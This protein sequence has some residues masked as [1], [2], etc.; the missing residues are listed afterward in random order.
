MKLFP[1]F[2]IATALLLLPAGT[3]AAER[4]S[5]DMPALDAATVN[6]YCTYKSG[7]KNY[8]TTGTGIM[9]G[10]RGVILTNAHVVLPLLIENPKNKS[11][12]AVRAGSPAREVYTASLLYLAPSWLEETLPALRKR[13][14]RGSGD[15][16]FALLYVASSTSSTSFPGLALPLIPSA[17][18]EGE[19][20]ILAGY[21][22]EG[23]GYKK[24]A[25]KLMYETDATEVASVHSF[26]R[27]F[28]DVLSL[29][30]SSLARSG[31]S[32]GPVARSSGE[33]VGLMTAVEQSEKKSERKLR[34]ITLSYI[35]RAITLQTGLPLSLLIS[36]NLDARAALTEAGLPDELVKDVASAQLRRR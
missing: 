13:V 20:V 4:D 3:F 26:I 21:P 14:M 12:C 18:T 8:S 10:D 15:G 11:G 29:A 1:A 25:K 2:L 35:D 34:A 30:P 31:V 5:I 22:A 19:E 23:L 16:D 17:P 27:P 7:S 9:L 6:I 24:T 28:T 36:G 32:G 33:L